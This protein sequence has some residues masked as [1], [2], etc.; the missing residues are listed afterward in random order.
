MR[1]EFDEAMDLA[2]RFRTILKDDGA[3]ASYWFFAEVPFNVQMLAGQ[4]QQAVET[5]TE[6]ND[7]L[8]RMGERASVLDAMLSQALYACDELDAA[9]RR[10]ED[11][12][13]SSDGD[14]VSARYQARG[15]LAKILAREGDMGPAESMAHESV[16]FFANTEFLV[17]HAN[18]LLDLGEVLGLAGR[19]DDAKTT[20]TEAIELLERKGDIVTAERARR[21]LEQ[22]GVTTMP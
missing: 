20:I 11:A 16:S 10:A 5:L 14:V 4:T 18:V 8:G 2:D 15:V 17:D 21:M 9:R 1:G 19:P 6:A 13:A 22:I 12:C 7:Q 3:I